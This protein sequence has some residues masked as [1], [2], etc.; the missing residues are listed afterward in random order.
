[1]HSLLYLSEWFIQQ[2]AIHHTVAVASD[3]QLK[4]EKSLAYYQLLSIIPYAGS[5]T[6]SFFLPFTQ[7]RMSNPATENLFVFLLL[8][9]PICFSNFH[10]WWQNI[11][12]IFYQ[13]IL[14]RSESSP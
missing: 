2:Y 1:M 9:F 7:S 4:G 5:A 6:L 10:S 3:G 8:L 12:G 11:V 13:Q 14:S